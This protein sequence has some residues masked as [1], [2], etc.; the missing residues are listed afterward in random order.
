[1]DAWGRAH[2]VF[3]TNRWVPAETWCPAAQVI[4]MLERLD[5]DHAYPN[6][7]VNRWLAA[8]LRL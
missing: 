5:P 1:M 6:W 3:C 8:L 4:A 7:A 2:G